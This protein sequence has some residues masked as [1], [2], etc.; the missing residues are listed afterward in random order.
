MAFLGISGKQPRTYKA[1]PRYF[2]FG[3]IE[4]PSG[5]LHCD[6]A[7]GLTVGMIIYG[8]S[9]A[10]RINHVGKKESIMKPKKNT[11]PS[12]QSDL[13]Q[14]RLSKAELDRLV[15]EA[16]V[17]CY[18]ES[19]QVT[20]LYTMIED[21]LQ[22]P[23]ETEVLGVQVTVTAVDITDDDRIVA[24][25]QRGSKTQKIPVSDLTLPHPRPVGSE[26]IDAYRHWARYG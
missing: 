14:L 15:E 3:L 12:K 10:R 24:V 5:I 1:T 6:F 21:N 20:G 17:D 9:W 19:E 8:S 2:A 23:F 13:S 16:T 18:N 7:L 25:C 11:Q 4:M 22:L 26:W